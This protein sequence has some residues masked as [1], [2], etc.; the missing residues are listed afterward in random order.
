MLQTI[1]IKNAILIDDIEIQFKSG[2]TVLTGQTGAG[3]S[4]LVSAL[5]F[6]LGERASASF[7]KRNCDYAMVTAC[8]DVNT[9]PELDILLNELS[10]EHT[11]ILILRR[12]IAVDGKSK[13]YINDTPISINTLRNIALLLIEIGSQHA[14]VSLLNEK[15]HQQILDDYGKL[16]ES[17]IEVKKIYN[18]Y[19]QQLSYLAKQK[20]LA[21]NAEIEKDYLSHV[22]KELSKLN[23]IPN[24]EEE[25]ISKRQLL[26]KKQKHT[27]TLQEILYEIK[28]KEILSFLANAQKL[29]AKIDESND[30][31]KIIEMFEK[32]YVE[33]DE[34]IN[35]IEN[36]L[37]KFSET[38]DLV[39]SEER[40]FTLKAAA[41]KYNSMVN[42]LS[43]V[44]NE[45]NQKL[46]HLNNLDQIIKTEEIKLLKLKSLYKDNA[47]KLSKERK[48]AAHLLEQAIKK[49]L[50]G[51]KMD[52]MLF[53]V[54]CQELPEEKWQAE[55][56]DKIYF[57]AANPGMELAPISKIASGGELSRFMLAAKVILA[58]NKAIPSIVFD[59]IDTGISGDVADA[60]ARRLARLAEINQ[61]IVV[62][63]LPQVAAKANHQLLVHKKSTS[64]ETEVMITELS[65][66]ERQEEL[67]RMLSGDKI[68]QEARAAAKSLLSN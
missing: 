27:S 53:K 31:I 37:D 41:R 49:E 21:K 43:N 66:E 22:V 4:L 56:M 65:L 28:Q 11:G 54:I 35:Q 36:I 47:L 26:L 61:V 30:Y 2:L 42:D 10:I 14:Q 58:T 45:S 46:D 19:N 64:N 12:S 20:E 25:L 59:E 13:A 60:V 8:F 50:L 38:K 24:E 23:P 34:S 55:G 62:T 57:A 39:E 9:D 32:G 18:E 67:A 63:H 1:T 7:I 16:E 29:L 40:L 6:I 48:E 44:L 68:T 15:L 3:K 5:K 17:K 51:L 52:K 33:I